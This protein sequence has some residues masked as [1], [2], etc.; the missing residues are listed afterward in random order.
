MKRFRFFLLL[1]PVIFLAETGQSQNYFMK[2]KGVEGES[3]KEFYKGWIEL[4]SVT[5]TVTRSNAATGSGRLMAGRADFED[6]TISKKIDRTSPMLMQKCASGDMIDEVELE[7]P[8]ADGSGSYKIKLSDVR[9]SSVKSSSECKPRCEMMEEVSFNYS[10]ITWE[11]A[12]KSGA[13]VKAG[14]DLK[15]NKKI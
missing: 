8:S 5:Q 9:I 10:K 12:D 7:L 2:I 6:L 15:M 13:P 11:Y 1:L 4:N 3:K 14:Y